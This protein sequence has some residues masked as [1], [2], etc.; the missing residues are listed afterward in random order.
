MR[1]T[2]ASDPALP[3]FKH[4]HTSSPYIMRR[5]TEQNPETRLLTKNFFAKNKENTDKR[6]YLQPKG[7]RIN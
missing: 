1:L 4:L 2:S 6:F 3:F 7:M 5:T